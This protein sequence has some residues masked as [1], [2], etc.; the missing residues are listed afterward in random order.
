MY[1]NPYAKIKEN[2]INTATPEELTLML[3]NGA[4]K[5]LN[6]AAIAIE[7]KDYMQANTFIQ[8]TKD[9][10]REF[11]ITLDMKYEISEELNT[12][13]D[14]MHRR[15]TDANMKKD[16]EILNEVLEYLRLFR[17]TWKEAMK[18]ARASKI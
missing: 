1:N 13:Y 4:I 12:A 5:F 11:Q 14:Y 7:K 3:Y 16:L 6:Q 15:L 18:I 2:S 10:I 8:K 17:D 9:I